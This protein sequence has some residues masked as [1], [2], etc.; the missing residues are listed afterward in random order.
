MHINSYFFLGSQFNLHYIWMET[1]L[2]LNYSCEMVFTEL[3]SLCIISTIL[4]SDWLTTSAAL[5]EM[6]QTCWVLQQGG[7]MSKWDKIWRLERLNWMD[8]SNMSTRNTLKLDKRPILKNTFS[9]IQDPK[10]SF[11]G[12]ENSS[13]IASKMGA[14]QK[15][16]RG[17]W[18]KSKQI[19]VKRF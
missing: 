7:C 17:A 6:L 9:L 3:I 5:I 4:D 11:I 13:K 10:S 8:N 1:W 12:K 19:P 14:I 18:I 15:T 2:M 16:K